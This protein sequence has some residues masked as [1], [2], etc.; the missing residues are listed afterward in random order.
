VVY[1]LV[2]EITSSEK[3]AAALGVADLAEGNVN[4]RAVC[5]DDKLQYDSS[6]AGTRFSWWVGNVQGGLSHNQ[7]TAITTTS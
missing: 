6:G 2:L 4:D 3:S 7:E 5:L 1:S